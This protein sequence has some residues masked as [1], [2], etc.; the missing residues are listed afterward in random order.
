MEKIICTA[1][2]NTLPFQIVEEYPK[3]WITN[4]APQKM[5]MPKEIRL[6]KAVLSNSFEEVR[7]SSPTK[8]TTKAIKN[9]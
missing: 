1:V 5:P 6:P 9:E 3:N 4:L 2:S 8:K 7:H